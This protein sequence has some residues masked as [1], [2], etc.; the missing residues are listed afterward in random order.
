M[1]VMK[2]TYNIKIEGGIYKI[3]FE[4]Q[5]V[6]VKRIVNEIYSLKLHGEVKYNTRSIMNIVLIVYCRVLLMK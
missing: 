5:R 3:H 2:N 6:S 4:F 1:T